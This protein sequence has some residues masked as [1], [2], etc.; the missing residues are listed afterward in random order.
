MEQLTNIL[1][2]IDDPDQIGKDDTIQQCS[3]RVIKAA[4]KVEITYKKRANRNSGGKPARPYVG[5]YC[6]VSQ[7]ANGN[8][9]LQMAW[10]KT[11]DISGVLNAVKLDLNKAADVIQTYSTHKE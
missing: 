2:V 10:P 3:A 5:E 9:V 7:Y 6:F 8:L 4:K 1:V 11:S